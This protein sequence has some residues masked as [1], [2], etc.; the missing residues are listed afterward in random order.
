M[1]RALAA[2]AAAMVIA[3]AGPVP[4]LAAPAASG[5][6]PV[7]EARGVVRYNVGATHSARAAVLPARLTR[8][9]SVVQG[10]DVADDDH[11][12][13]AAIDWPKVARAGYRFAFIKV[14]EGS[15]Y[16]NRYYAQDSAGAQAAGMFVAPYA[17]AIPNF[18]SATLQADY[19]INASHYAS[20]GNILAP[21]LDIEYDP[22]AGL[23]GTPAGSWCYGLRPGPMVAWIAAFISEAR[24]R[25]GQLPIIYTTAQ[26][27]DRCTR[28]S[29]SFRADPLWISGNNAANT[30]P[31][32]PA[33]W[34]GW[35]F[36]QY[37][38]LASV[39]GISVVTDASYLSSSALQLAAPARQSD[40][41]ASDVGLRVRLL[42]GGGTVTYTASGLPPGLSID[43]ASGV[44][45]G[46]LPGEPAT[47]PVSVSATAR[48]KQTATQAFTWDAHG[49]VTLG[50]L[51]AL[52]G[53]VA[54]PVLQ[55]VAAFDSL[56]GCTLTFLAAGLPP[57]LSMT[58]C[59]LLSGWPQRIGRYAVT[60]RVTDSSG[61]ELAGGSFRWT[62]NAATARGPT[63][64]I[65]LAVGGR[66]LA[67]LSGTNVAVEPCRSTR[68]QLWTIA[69]D[70]L[71]RVAGQC[72][73]ARNGRGPAP[74]GLRMTRCGPRSQRWQQGSDAVL[75]N[76]SDGRCLSASGTASGSRVAA[77]PCRTTSNPSGSVSTPT[78]RQKWDLP[79]GPLAS[80][81]PGF[82]A[83]G[84]V[85]LGSVTLR[86]CDGTA[87]QD[88]ADEPDGT[89]GTSGRCLGLARGG[90]APGTAVRLYR[91]SRAASEFWQLSGGPIGVR[92]LS[93]VSGLCL[94]DPGDSAVAG[95][96]LVAD[97][98]SGGDPG[99]SWRVG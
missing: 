26:W 47:F 78:P 8:A 45:G 62:V 1:H 91:C 94:A 54:A 75:R 44:I 51:A 28:D 52:T 33:A 32:M 12:S 98:C 83:S 99:I 64:H 19:A 81:L 86:P 41:A 15:Y 11:P 46:T 5:Q 30:A 57:G 39:P 31:A 7:S 76:L 55:Q 53:S 88:W 43:S 85:G 49:S 42:N 70:G 21:I 4:A 65:R 3:V 14:S 23:D 95:T 50:P 80:G 36:W 48:G 84:D 90:T 87:A 58:G 68:S 69:T 16:V 66:C 29:R 63:G 92:L 34:R 79:P 97:P 20:D 93:P 96:A 38:Y 56:P 22:Y 71:V 24:R 13:G 17:F 60:V 67:R 6:R 35:T 72:L 9:A 73:A 10:V 89:I 77:A 37:T 18:S 27:W 25:T 2:V 59:G 61:R 82:C 74:V 40:Q